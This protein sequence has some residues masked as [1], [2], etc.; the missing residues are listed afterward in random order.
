MADEQ[1]DPSTYDLPAGMVRLLGTNRANVKTFT[2]SADKYIDLVKHPWSDL[3]A[4]LAAVE[5][6]PFLERLEAAA[7]EADALASRLRLAAEIVRT[8]LDDHAADV[9]R[10]M[11]AEI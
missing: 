11:L 7:V 5:D 8:R 1:F 9:T 3:L 4:K 2:D 6:P 10:A